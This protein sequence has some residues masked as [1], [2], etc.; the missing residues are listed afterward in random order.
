MVLAGQFRRA[1]AIGLLSAAMA[2]A[3]M[4]AVSRARADNGDDARH[5]RSD[6][7]TAYP[8]KRRY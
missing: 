3:G 1:C 4:L 5:S 8:V 7:P 2:N 6:G